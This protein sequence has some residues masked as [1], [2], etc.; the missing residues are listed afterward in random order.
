MAVC[1]A[2]KDVFEI[3][4]RLDVIE[5]CGCGERADGGPPSAATVGAGEQVILAPERD[6]P[7]CTLDRIVVEID[8]AI[9]QE[10][11]KG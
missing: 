3:G 5:L 7:D 11:A 4:E 9:V 8:T 10:T 6:G 1:H 2:L